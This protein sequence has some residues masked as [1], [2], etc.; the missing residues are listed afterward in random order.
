MFLETL[1]I[2][3]Q[4]EPK[5]HFHDFKGHTPYGRKQAFLL[6]SGLIMFI[7]TVVLQ[8]ATMCVQKVLSL[9]L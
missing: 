2:E 4:Y 9:F 1:K 8:K 6:G 7:G 3:H 5:L